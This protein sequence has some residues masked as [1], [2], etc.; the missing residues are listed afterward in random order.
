MCLG[1][2]QSAWGK[3]Y[4]H[5]SL[6]ITFLAAILIFELGSLVCAVAPNATALIV[7]RA[8][9]GL[10]AAGL[11]TGAYTILGFAAE[12]KKR[13]M[14]T[15]IIGASYGIASV[16]GPLVGGA[17]ADKVT[18]RWCFYVN[19]PIGGLSALLVVLFF[20]TPSTANSTDL[21]LGEK[22]RQLDPVGVALVM[23]AMISYLLALQYGGQLHPW[24]SSVVV[25]LLVGF[26]VISVTFA[27]WE[28]SQ[29]ERAM[30]P[31]RLIKQRTYLVACLFTFFFAGAYFVII[32]YLP[33]YFQ[34]I[35]GVSPIDSGVRNLPL[36]LAVT[37][38]T[39]IS[40]GSITATGLASP[41]QLGGTAIATIATGLIYTLDIGSSNGKW[42]G[43]Q[44]LAG[45]G[46]GA[47]FQ[48]PII[49][50]QATASPEDLAEVTA[51]ILCKLSRMHA[52]S[53]S[54]RVKTNPRYCSL[55]NRRWR[56]FNRGRAVCLR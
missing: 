10:G 24:N 27:A 6:K 46:Y 16:A 21:P 38:A 36:I 8:I 40:G 14:F 56:I 35:D 2:F 42:I 34:S 53:L 26:V 17:F 31:V 18:W 25:G 22:L 50:G 9:A 47:A 41:I 11:A 52:F 23:G 28:Y 37:V 13:P 32:Y 43:Y 39:I 33:I 45:L 12:P 29:G 44:I 4:K 30:V 51:I 15:G 49:I 7:G 55:S 54:E 48:I 5:F 3:V 20:R 1:G 19:L